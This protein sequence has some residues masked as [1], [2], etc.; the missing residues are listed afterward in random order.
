MLRS[1]EMKPFATKSSLDAVVV[2]IPELRTPCPT[3]VGDRALGDVDEATATSD[4]PVQAEVVVLEQI[5]ALGDVRHE[6]VEPAA[7]ERVA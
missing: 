4:H 5:A 7:I 1:A 2:E 3:R 6:G